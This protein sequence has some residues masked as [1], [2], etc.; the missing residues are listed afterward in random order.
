LGHIDFAAADH[1]AASCG[2]MEH[3]PRQWWTLPALFGG[4]LCPA[5]IFGYLGYR[6]VAKRWSMRK[7]VAVLCV[8][9][10]GTAAY[11]A[12]PYLVR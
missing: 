11:Y 8:A 10:L 4:L 6:A 3:C 1:P 12:S 7:S 2:E 9:V 5:I